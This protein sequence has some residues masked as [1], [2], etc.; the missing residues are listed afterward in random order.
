MKED[1]KNIDHIRMIQDFFELSYANYLAIP[2]SVLQSMPDEW[3]KDFVKLLDQLDETFDWRR[4]GCWVQFRNCK[5]KFMK[6]ELVDYQRGRRHFLPEELSG[7]V[8]R[9]NSAF[10][11]PNRYIQEPQHD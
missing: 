9:H 2:R 7:I 1:C 11:L 6:D 3:Q 10:N 4:E 8:E 5:G